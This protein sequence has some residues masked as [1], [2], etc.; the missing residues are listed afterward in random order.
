MLL[1]KLHK[2]LV[3]SLIYSFMPCIFFSSSSWEFNIKKEYNK[4]AHLFEAFALIW[5]NDAIVEQQLL[6]DPPEPEE[7][8]KLVHVECKYLSDNESSWMLSI[9]KEGFCSIDKLIKNLITNIKIMD[10]KKWWT[11]TCIQQ[12]KNV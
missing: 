12:W 1:L 6:L 8:W 5:K 9:S 4:S 10:L 11:E 7:E 3:K 2:Y